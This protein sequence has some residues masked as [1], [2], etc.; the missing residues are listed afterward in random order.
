MRLQSEDKPVLAHGKS[1][2]RRLGPAD[3][4]AQAVVAPAAEQGILRAQS[5]MREFE[6]GPGVV[7]QAANQA[8]IACVGNIGGIERRRHLY[9]V[10]LGILVK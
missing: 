6:R 8:V 4:L 1:D 3:R 2:S 5:A 7:V 10:R 9:K